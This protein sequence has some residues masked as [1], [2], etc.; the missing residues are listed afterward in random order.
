M[1]KGVPRAITSYNMLEKLGR[2]RLSEHFF[3]RDFLYSSIGDFYGIPNYPENPA[4]AVESGSRL[5]QELLEPL[6][7]KF[8]HIV[9]RSAYRSPSVNAR[10]AANGNEHNCASNEANFARHIWDYRDKEGN[11]GATVCIQVHWFSEKYEEGADW[12]SL[13]WW[14]H[15]HLPYNSMFFFK[16]RA[17]FNLNWRENPQKTIKSWIGNKRV[18]TK[19]DMD[20]WDGDHSKHYKWIDE[21]VSG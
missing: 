1:I 19:P 13:A 20:N 14:I 8:G 12:R 16:N 5:C 7:K 21:E 2:V 6:K 10:G 9:I 18:L 15:D 11:M 17:A 3:M 4:L